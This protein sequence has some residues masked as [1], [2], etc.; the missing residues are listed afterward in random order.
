MIKIL[1]STKSYPPVVGGSAFLL[2]ELVRHF[3]TDELFVV[4]GTNDPPLHSELSL[5]FK[6][7]QVLW[8][9]NP[10]QTLRLNRY[11]PEAYIMLIR[12]QIRKMIQK[13]NINQIYIH[14]PNGAFAVAAYKEA[15][16]A[17]IPYIFYQDILWEEREKGA[18]LKLAKKYE[19]KIIRDASARIAITEFAA[20]YQQEKHNALYAVIPHTV[21]E[22]DIVNEF[23]VLKNQ[24]PKI[25]FAGGIYPSM[26][27][28]SVVRLIESVKDLGM[29]I[30]LEF[31]SPDKPKSLLNEKID[32]KYL[33]KKD[34]ILTQKS[35]DIL[36]LP[37]AFQSDIPEMIKYN[38]PTKTMEYICSGR[39][40][41]VHSPSDSYLSYLCKKEGFGYLVDSPDKE[42]LKLAIRELVTNDKLQR[43]LVSN[44]LKLARK[45]ISSFW[46]NE[47]SEVLKTSK[48]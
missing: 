34:L 28:D 39:P 43:E 13:E 2:Y 30:D 33:S 3:S 35:S 6:R 17:N 48:R 23:V 31:C 47:L 11:F 26:N 21:D 7:K 29:D 16:R 19:S 36:F 25:H 14:Y 32:W 38:F 42:D 4:H 41:L 12:I 46:Q 40:I 5:P 8:L 22:K 15:K 27:K 24:R 45:R 1:L 18:E 20:K 44:A 37:Q 9:G 10:R